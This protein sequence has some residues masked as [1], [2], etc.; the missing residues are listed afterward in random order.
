MERE[1]LLMDGK[2][3]GSQG[4]TLSGKKKEIAEQWLPVFRNMGGGF[5]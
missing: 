5:T 2:L 4:I 1:K 3:Y